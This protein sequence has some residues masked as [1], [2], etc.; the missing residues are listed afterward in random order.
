MQLTTKIW[1][2]DSKG[3]DFVDYKIKPDV[4]MVILDVIHR[5]Q[6]EQANDMA[7]R[8]NCKAGKF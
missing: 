1:R 8:W 5:I 3:G 4:G 2:G 7:V 6:A